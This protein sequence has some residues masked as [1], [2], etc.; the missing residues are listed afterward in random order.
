MIAVLA[1]I[2]RLAGLEIDT[3]IQ[4][5]LADAAVTLAGAVGGLLAIYGRLAATMAIRGEEG[6]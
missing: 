2:A 3:D 6:R 4:G 5:E 1:A